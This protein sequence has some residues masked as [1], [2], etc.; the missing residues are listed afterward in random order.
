MNQSCEGFSSFINEDVFGLRLSTQAMQPVAALSARKWALSIDDVSNNLSA[1][2]RKVTSIPKEFQKVM[3]ATNVNRNSSSVESI[4]QLKV[5]NFP[6]CISSLLFHYVKLA[7]FSLYMF[8]LFL[9]VYQLN[10][11]SKLDIERRRRR[12]KTLLP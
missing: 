1:L 9:F 12:S 3:I 8:A 11:K 4:D 5:L 6:T 2:N 10:I 7:S